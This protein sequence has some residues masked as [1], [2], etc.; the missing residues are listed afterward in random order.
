MA[1]PFAPKA[2]ASGC[3]KTSIHSLEKNTMQ[4]SMNIL[5]CRTRSR[6]AGPKQYGSAR[7]IGNLQSAA[8]VTGVLR[9]DLPSPA[10]SFQL[11]QAQK[12]LRS[13]SLKLGW[14]ACVRVY[15][16]TFIYLFIGLITLGL[17]MLGGEKKG[18]YFTVVFL[19]C[20]NFGAE[21]RNGCKQIFCSG[22]QC[23]P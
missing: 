11:F 18:N 10:H 21:G 4:I 22:T 16:N 3:R 6:G 8:E 5:S 19:I 7:S 13:C 14:S 15:I 9:Q 2:V 20:L 17:K 23:I 12:S 1:V